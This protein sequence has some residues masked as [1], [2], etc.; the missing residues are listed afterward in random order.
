MTLG[1]EAYPHKWPVNTSIPDIVREFSDIEDGARQQGKEVI[2]AGR[3]YSKRE[4]GRS[5]IFYD[6]QSGGKKIQVMSLEQDWSSNAEFPFV[7][8]HK[9]V[10]RGDWIGVRGNIGKSKRGTFSCSVCS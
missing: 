9:M 1:K 4:N 5:M 7:E 2:V 3:V 8:A 10:H 6:L